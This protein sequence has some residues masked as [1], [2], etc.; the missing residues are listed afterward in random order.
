MSNKSSFFRGVIH[1]GMYASQTPRQL[2]E[3]R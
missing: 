1:A 2:Q 3:D